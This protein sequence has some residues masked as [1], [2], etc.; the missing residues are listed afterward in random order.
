MTLEDK[1]NYLDIYRPPGVIERVET[2]VG[3]K[4]TQLDERIW[5]TMP[6]QKLYRRTK[7]DE[8]RDDRNYDRFDRGGGGSDTR[9]ERERDNPIYKKI[10]DLL[11]INLKQDNAN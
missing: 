11:A 5:N 6:T 2:N 8:K 1:K 4:S 10:E 7:P 9:K 3:L